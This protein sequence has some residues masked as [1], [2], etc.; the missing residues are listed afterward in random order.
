M[1]GLVGRKPTLSRACL[2]AHPPRPSITR[3]GRGTVFHFVTDGEAALEQ[4]NEAAGSRDVRLGGGV[5]A[6]RQYLTTHLID[7]MRMVVTPVL[8]GAG[9]AL[10][11]GIDLPRLG[12]EVTEHVPSEKVTHVVLSKR[13]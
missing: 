5:A 9:E 13:A 6:I 7:H 4:A 2:R 11:A 1:A 3:N 12:Y 10:F 8:L